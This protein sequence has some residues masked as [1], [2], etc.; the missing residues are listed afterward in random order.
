MQIQ[1]AV[2]S[3]DFDALEAIVKK[4]KRAVRFLLGLSY[5]SDP[6]VRRNASRGIALAG[7][8]HKK[9]V[10]DVVRRLVW[11]M[12]DES[13]TNALTAPEVLNAIAEE[14]PDL[15]LPV[16]PDL[17]RLAGDEGLH[18]GLSETLHKVS[19][20]YPGKVG[21]KLTKALRGRIRQDDEDEEYS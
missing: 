14:K 16:V 17:I 11:A 2:D 6:E 9:L 5:Q 21:K 3:R 7:R 1:K 18:D 8:Y 4:E 20:A 12:N 13:G 15:L 19:Q 10:R